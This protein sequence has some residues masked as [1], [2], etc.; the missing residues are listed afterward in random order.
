MAKSSFSID[1]SVDEETGR[2]MAC[3]INLREGQAAETRELQPGRAYADYDDEGQL[4]G[5]EL[6]GPCSLTVLDSIAEKEP[7]SVK[8]FVLGAPPREL[9]LT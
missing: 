5:I 2:L 7:E 4:I 8:R 3:Y 6:L 9:V 1:V